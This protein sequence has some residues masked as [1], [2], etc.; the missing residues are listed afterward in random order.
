MTS[1]STRMERESN[2]KGYITFTQAICSVEAMTDFSVKTVRDVQ[3][4][5]IFLRLVYGKSYNFGR[6][7]LLF[8][9]FWGTLIAAE[10]ICCC[11]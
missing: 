2:A 9:S 1:M 5:D 7:L 4:N 11:H 10:K 8:I 6:K 3:R